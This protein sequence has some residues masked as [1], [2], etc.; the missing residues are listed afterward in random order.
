MTTTFTLDGVPY[1][2]DP[3]IAP[4]GSEWHFTRECPGGDA[5]PEALARGGDVVTLTE[6]VHGHAYRY[7]SPAA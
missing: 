3:Y 4:D 7:L 1:R 5:I 6:M 2:L